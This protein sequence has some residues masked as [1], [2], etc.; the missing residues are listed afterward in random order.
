MGKRG[1]KS[2]PVEDRFWLKVKRT[3]SCWIWIGSL[4]G[5]GY[6]QIMTNPKGNKR[7][8]ASRVSWQIHFGEIP[9]GMDVLHRCDNPPCVRPDHLFTGTARDNALD[10]V[11]KK[12]NVSR[13]PRGECVNTAKLTAIAVIKL[14]SDHTTGGFTY[15]DL[16]R[17]YGI[18]PVSA[19][20]IVLRRSWRHV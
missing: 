7:E 8:I 12:R 13:P 11:I 3:E 14:R 19:R 20:R 5:R 4:D 18:T 1:P 2:K 17:K 15:V 9:A 10:M 6:G 16:G